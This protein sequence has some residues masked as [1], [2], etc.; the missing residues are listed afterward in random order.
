MFLANLMGAGGGAAPPPSG[1]DAQFVTAATTSSTAAWLTGASQGTNGY[2]TLVEMTADQVGGSLTDYE[3]TTALGG[4]AASVQVAQ[5]TLS[6]FA[7]TANV[8]HVPR[9][10]NV[11]LAEVIGL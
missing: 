10:Y 1:T 4:D 5:V 8:A 6:I 2:T 9:L 11:M 3:T 7:S